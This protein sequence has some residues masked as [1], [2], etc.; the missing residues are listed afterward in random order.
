[1]NRY[2]PSSP[3]NIDISQ[4]LITKDDNV[5]YLQNHVN[6]DISRFP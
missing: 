3:Q 4:P 6:E 2:A 1:M 5:S